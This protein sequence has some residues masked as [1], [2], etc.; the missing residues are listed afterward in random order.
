M[1][2]E[3]MVVGDE[4]VE[5]HTF[6]KKVDGMI[7]DFMATLCGTMKMAF[8]EKDKFEKLSMRFHNIFPTISRAKIV[9]C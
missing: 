5:K 7:L 6:L 4:I 8:F 2:I 1:I 9:T 3:V